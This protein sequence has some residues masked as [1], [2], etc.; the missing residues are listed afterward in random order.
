MIMA[1][2]MVF[3]HLPIPAM[4][5]EANTPIGASGE[6]IVF[7]PLDETEK[8]VEVGTSI[9]ELE[10]P[11][12]LAATVRMAS[13]TDSGASEP[14]IQDSGS[15][16]EYIAAENSEPS[17][18][19][20]AID[21]NLEEIE[22]NWE[23]TT[24]DILVTWTSQP[25]YDMD[26]VGTYVFIPVVG[27]YAVSADLPEIKVTVGAVAAPVMMLTAG[28][29]IEFATFANLQSA[30]HNAKSNLD[31]KLSDSYAESIGTLT[32]ASGNNYN[33]TIDLNGKTLDSGSNY[34]I[35]HYGGGTL[36][37]ND[38]SDDKNGKVTANSIATIIIESSSGNVHV[39]DGIVENTQG[40]AI[41]CRG[42][43]IVNISGGTVRSMGTSG[44]DC[45]AIFSYGSVKCFRRHR[46]LKH[47][48]RDCGYPNIHNSKR[49]A[50]Y[51][52]RL[53]GDEQSS[54]LEQLS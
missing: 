12:T 32:I 37:I 41:V 8:T 4:A 39:L 31:L 7:T 54:G 23:E 52:R 1:L 10:L 6:I 45:Y 34:A 40:T 27:G 11:E 30:I 47:L 14:P 46:E 5:E 43:G 53:S 18:A 22:S 16:E 13:T 25:E 19:G 38:S 17:K 15:G 35:S 2:S 50:H 28:T 42:A 24:V 33:I 51:K 3:T 44:K 21:S 26:T 36:T 48:R 49:L 9:E 29:P 20:E